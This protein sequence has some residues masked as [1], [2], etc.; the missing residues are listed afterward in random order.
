[1]EKLRK[2]S[3]TPVQ[4]ADALGVILDITFPAVFEV[5]SVETTQGVCDNSIECIIGDILEGQTVVV[6]VGFKAPDENGEFNISAVVT[7]LGQTFTNVILVIVENN[8]DGCSLAS[9][10]GPASIPLYLLIPVIIPLRRIW[11]RYIKTR[12]RSAG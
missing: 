3:L 6:I 5:E 7:T 4:K 1:L 2:S 10:A 9:A 8:N 11:K 12:V